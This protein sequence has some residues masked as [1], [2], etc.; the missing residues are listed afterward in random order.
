MIAEQIDSK[1]KL[2]IEIDRNFNEVFMI[3]LDM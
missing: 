3:I 1:E 2:F